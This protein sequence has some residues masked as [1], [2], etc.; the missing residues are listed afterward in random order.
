MIP[1]ASD[2]ATILLVLGYMAQ[3][4]AIATG[5]RGG[6][7]QVSNAAVARH[8]FLVSSGIW[9]LFSIGELGLFS[10]VISGSTTWPC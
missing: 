3:V 4:V 2:M 10:F 9:L 5:Q 1:P 8:P 7:I 6:K